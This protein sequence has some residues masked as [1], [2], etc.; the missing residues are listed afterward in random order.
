MLGT[1]ASAVVYMLSLTAIF[2]IVPTGTLADGGAPFSTA[3]DTMFGGRLWGDAMAA[4]V[5]ISGIGALNGWTMVTAE[6]PR[7]AAADGLFQ[8]VS[9]A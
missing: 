8:N 6:M 5:I 4:V 2:G 9:A 1:L 7:A 3:V